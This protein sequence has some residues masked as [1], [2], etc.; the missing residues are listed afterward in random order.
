LAWGRRLTRQDRPGEVERGWR[1]S[2]RAAVSEDWLGAET[3]LERIVAD[4]TSDLD[5]YHALAGLYRRQGAV[6][7]AIRMHQ[8]LLLRSD[9]EKSDRADALLE[10][11]RDFEEGGFLQRAAASYEEF[12]ARRPR[13]PEAIERLIGICR[14]LREFDRALALVRK[15]RRRDRERADRLEIETLL[16]MAQARSDAGDHDAA[17]QALKRCL[18]RDRDCSPAYVLLGE[19][20]AERGKTARAIVAWRRAVTLDESL[21]RMLYPKI[22][23]GFVARGKSEDHE[24]MLR[25]ILETRPMDADARIAL[26]RTL[27]SRGEGQTA[28]EELSRAI[29]VAPEEVGLR[30]ELGRQLLASDQDGE[31]LKAYRDLVELL[32]RSPG[33]LREEVI[34]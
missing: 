3:W 7:R 15:L 19:L 8:N 9:L 11:A 26:A 20:E 2:L 1:R 24:A 16:A 5:A 12:L 28:I 32:E 31:A 23:A 22:E 4:D 30:A 17:R 33:L 14:D 29:E 25:E 34:E 18:R 21:G 13:S 10:L 6:G 27:G